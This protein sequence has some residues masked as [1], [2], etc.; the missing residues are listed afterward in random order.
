MKP[1]SSSDAPLSSPS[2]TSGRGAPRSG[3]G[4]RKRLD[5]IV[6]GAGFGGMCAVHRFRK[7][8]LSVAGFEAGGDVGGVW[9]WNRYP[10]A[11]VD[12]P[13]IDY[14]YSFPEIEQEWTWSE[15]FA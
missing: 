10:G 11:R 13:S 4:G 2:T 7:L 1:A 14:S 12:L 15:Q 9:Y 5:V 8:G 6:V 3:E